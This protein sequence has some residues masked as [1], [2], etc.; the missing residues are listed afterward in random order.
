M[1]QEGTEVESLPNGTLLLILVN[2]EGTK[3]EKPSRTR[4]LNLTHKLTDVERTGRFIFV[5]YSCCNEGSAVT[6]ILKRRVGRTV[7]VSE[8]V[9]LQGLTLRRLMSYIY[10]APILDVSRSHTTTQ[11]SR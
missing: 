4:K 9:A 8:M 1:W 7:T 10:G 5:M 6:D 3:A 2:K 11:H